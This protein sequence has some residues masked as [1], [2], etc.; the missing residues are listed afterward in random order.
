LLGPS[1]ATQH[2]QFPKLCVLFR[3]LGGGHVR[4]MLVIAH[5]LGYIIYMYTTLRDFVLLPSSRNG[6]YRISNSLNNKVVS[7]SN[8]WIRSRPVSHT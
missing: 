2:I 7:Y 1:F 8:V 5:C 4:I 3:T 6:R